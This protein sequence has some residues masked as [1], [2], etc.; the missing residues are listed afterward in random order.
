[1]APA[2]SSTA[3]SFLWSLHS[4]SFDGAEHSQWGVCLYGRTVPVSICALAG[5]D[6]DVRI[7]AVRV[8]GRPE[9]F[10][11]HRAF[12]GES[13]LLRGPTID[14]VLGHAGAIFRVALALGETGAL[15]FA[16]KRTIRTASGSRHPDS[17][18]QVPA[19]PRWHAPLIPAGHFA[20][21]A[22]VVG[23]DALAVL[24][25]ALPRLFAIGWSRAIH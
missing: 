3:G 6:T 9:R 22:A 11:H 24:L 25:F 14:V 1:M 21:R 17:T 4:E 15:E 19:G 10:A 2:N 7:R 8:A 16:G 20:V 23:Q 13:T 18:T 5:H 12:A